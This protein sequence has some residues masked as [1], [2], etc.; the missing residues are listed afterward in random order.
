MTQPVIHGYPDFG[1]Y[2]AQSDKFLQHQLNL[3]ADAQ[4]NYG[5]FFVGDVR[6]I[7]IIFLA[8]VNHF[9]VRLEFYDSSTL[10]NFMGSHQAA[11]RAQTNLSTSFPVLGPWMRVE[12]EPSAINAQ[13]EISLW[14]TS[15]ITQIVLTGP[16]DCIMLSQ[17]GN[18]PAGLTNFLLPNVRMGRCVLN[19]LLPGTL[20]NIVIDSID[21]LG[22][23]RRIF[24]IQGVNLSDTPKLI[25]P[26][27]TINLSV[28]NFAAGPQFYSVVLVSDPTNGW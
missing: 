9:S 20:S 12:I 21:H 24:A 7:G 15:A 3:D 4:V 8:I 11:V 6:A 18:L 1:R 17:V 25:L 22:V 14:T 23:V 27:T 10:T 2:Q 19:Y 13:Y 16:E 26:P 5:P 28:T